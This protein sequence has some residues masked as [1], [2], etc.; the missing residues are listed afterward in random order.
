[1]ARPKHRTKPGGTYF[2]TTN[3]WERRPLFHKGPLAEIVVRKLIEYRERGFYLLHSYVIM[4]DHVHLILTPN[5][6]ASLEKAIQM[7]KG[8]SSHEIGMKVAS[9]FPVWQAGFTEHQIR[10]PEDFMIHVRYIDTNPLNAKLASRIGEY[11]FCSANGD[12]ML[13]ACPVASGAKAHEIL[14]PS[15]RRG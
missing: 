5:K 15:L 8:G 10:D 7:I 1:M 2:V 12:S 13:D 4:P 9:K 14:A 3:T 11:P 6:S